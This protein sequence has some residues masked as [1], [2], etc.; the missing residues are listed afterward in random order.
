MIRALLLVTVVACNAADDPPDDTLP[1]A[2][3]EPGA[4]RALATGLTGGTEG[5]AVLDGEIYVGQRDDGGVDEV[6]S[7]PAVV[8]LAAWRG[9]IWAASW[10]DEAGDAKPALVHFAPGGAATRLDIAEPAKPNF[11]LP[12]PWDTLLVS[13]DFDTRLFASDGG[14]PAVWADGFTSP[15]GMGLS[16]D[17]ATL[18]VANTFGAETPLMSLA[19][20]DGQPTAAPVALHDFGPGT[21]PDGLLMAA[22]GTVL[23]ALNLANAIAAWDGATATTLVSDVPFPASMA[24]SPDAACELVVTSLFGDSVWAV[25]VSLAGPAD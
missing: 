9:E 10:E 24:W 6:A 5:I 8:G 3:P 11:L 19:V 14:A 12:T 23:V 18:F 20:A 13:D 15:N 22:D 4:P 16:A 2:C 1:V 25:P 21:T 7:V 17:N